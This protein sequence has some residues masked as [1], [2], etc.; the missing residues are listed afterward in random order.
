MTRV[1][2]KVEKTEKCVVIFETVCQVLNGLNTE[3]P[4]GLTTA[5]KTPEIKH[6]AT[7]KLVHKC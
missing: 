3:I 5:L 1:D 2:E 4:N 7:R 6:L